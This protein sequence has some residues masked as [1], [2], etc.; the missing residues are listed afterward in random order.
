MSP[1]TLESNQI[2]A[3]IKE[4]ILELFQENRE[5]V[6]DALTEIME[7][8]AL[9]RAMAVAEDSELVSREEVFKILESV[10]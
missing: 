5:I 10:E 1:I 4:A 6:T 7:D 8:I 2:K 9:E 3:V